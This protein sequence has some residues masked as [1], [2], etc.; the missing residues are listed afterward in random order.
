VPLLRLLLLLLGLRE[1]QR[2]I[3]FGP[4]GGSP[5]PRVVRFAGYHLAGIAEAGDRDR[6]RREATADL[7]DVDVDG[8][9]IG[10]DQRAVGEEEG[11]VA[12][13]GGIEE[14]GASFA[15]SAGDQRHAAAWLGAGSHPL[16]LPLVDVPVV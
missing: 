15:A 14:G 13:G 16:G 1:G 3:A 2:R 9:G 12:A 6:R 11:L 7:G 8:A 5:R 4:V 10:R